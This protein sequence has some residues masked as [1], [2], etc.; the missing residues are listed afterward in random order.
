MLKRERIWAKLELRP[1]SPISPHEIDFSHFPANIPR[2][3]TYPPPT[4]NQQ[5]SCE[6]SHPALRSFH[7]AVTS[8]SGGDRPIFLDNSSDDDEDD[9]NDRSDNNRS[10]DDRSNDDD[11]K[12]EHSHRKTSRPLREY[13]RG[14][15]VKDLVET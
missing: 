4:A 11:G 12:V 15:W 14:V 8:F 1:M 9:D 2:Q 13:E 3:T 5:C 6:E 10:D 7:S